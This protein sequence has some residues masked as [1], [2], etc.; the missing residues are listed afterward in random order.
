[1]SKIELHYRTR[2][3]EKVCTDLKKAQKTYSQRVATALFGL[4]NVLRAAENLND[5]NNLRIYN[6]HH[7]QGSRLGEFALDIDGRSS[8]YRLIF[9]PLA[10]SRQPVMEERD[11]LTYFYSRIKIIEIQEVSNHYEH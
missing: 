11:N 7:L 8:G 5:I 10:D 4:L 9:V 3:V 2:K 1:M 6:L